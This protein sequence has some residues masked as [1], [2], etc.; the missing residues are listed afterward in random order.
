MFEYI[1]RK[2]KKKILIDG[3]NVISKI[4]FRAAFCT[5]CVWIPNRHRLVG[6]WSSTNYIVNTTYQQL[7]N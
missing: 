2:G 7:I 3:I 4:F 5:G 6:I 1:G